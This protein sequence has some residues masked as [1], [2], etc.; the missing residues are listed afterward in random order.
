MGKLG[1][2]FWRKVN[3]TETCWLWT[4]FVFRTGYGGFHQTDGRK[5]VHRLS[6][7]HFN[8]PIPDGKHIHHK[9]R[10]RLC[11]NPEHLELVD[12]STHPDTAASINRNKTHCPQGHLYSERNTYIIPSTRGR[13]CK[14]CLENRRNI[15]R[16]N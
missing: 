14:T 13:L 9:C 10:I 2:L 3:K 4:G 8:G 11:V 15:V 5:L 16:Y 7:E 12:L 6:F 1:R